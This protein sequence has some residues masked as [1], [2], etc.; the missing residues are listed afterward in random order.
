MPDPIYAIC[1]YI[2]DDP[3]IQALPLVNDPFPVELPTSVDVQMPA[4]MVVVKPHGG[5][6]DPAPLQINYTRIQV[7]CFAETA[8]LAYVVDWT[9]FLVLKD[10]AH[11]VRAGTYIHNC[12]R[13]SGPTPFRDPELQ[14]PYS[15][16]TWRLM[17]S[18]LAA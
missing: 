4:K 14:W 17:A 6:E 18:D 9:V 1:E 12:I 10:L 11:V 2:R 16:S 3:T 15:L 5:P 8:H 7:Q 13:M